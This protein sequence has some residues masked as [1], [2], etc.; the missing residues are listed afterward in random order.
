MV[1]DPTTMTLPPLEVPIRVMGVVTPTMAEFP[2]EIG[3]TS[4]F[5]VS[6]FN[7]EEI[8]EVRARF[9]DPGSCSAISLVC[10]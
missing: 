5:L 7:C 10:S 4:W 1:L 3:V 9:S 2:A 8:V 6:P